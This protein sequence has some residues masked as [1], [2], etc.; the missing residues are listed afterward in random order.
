MLGYTPE[1]MKSKTIADISP[2]GRIVEYFEFFKQV[3]S[4]GK[5]FTEIE[6]LKKD[7]NYIS[8]D[9]NAVLLPDGLVYGSCRD[10]TERRL[11]EQ[12]LKESETGKGSDFK[13]TMPKNTGQA[14]NIKN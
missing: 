1:E 12:T 7:G 13:F 5:V 6:L 9:L 8:T 14:I 3:L 2:P 10:I 4:E 11:A